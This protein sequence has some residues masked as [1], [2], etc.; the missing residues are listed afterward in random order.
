MAVIYALYGFVGVGKTTFAK[1]LE[2]ETNAVRF[3]HDEWMCDLY[4]DNP[5][6][7]LFS[8]YC[9]RVDKVIWRMAER[10][11]KSGSD[12]I[13]DFGFWKRADRDRL[14]AFAK[15]LGVGLRL[16]HLTCPE[17]VSKE[18]V[19]R[20]TEAMPEG[21]LWINEE[22]IEIFKTRFEPLDPLEEP[23]ILVDTSI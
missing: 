11:L 12:V 22:A 8:T 2:V 16:Y 10:I 14:R 23:S 19:L 13:F 1:K 5:P 6:E 3:T 9:A 15:A 17:A 18:R 21:A 20:R 4:G 7:E